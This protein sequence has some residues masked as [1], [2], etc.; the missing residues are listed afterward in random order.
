MIFFR[1]SQS[2]QSGYFQVIVICN[3]HIKLLSFI[4][5]KSLKL[6]EIPFDSIVLNMLQTHREKGLQVLCLVS[7]IYLSYY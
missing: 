6:L 7:G 5:G 2:L 1:Y 3:F 4:A